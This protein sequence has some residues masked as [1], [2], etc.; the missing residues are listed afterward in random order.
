MKPLK[1]TAA[2]RPPRTLTDTRLTKK[3]KEALAQ[4]SNVLYINV[5]DTSTVPKAKKCDLMGRFVIGGRGSE[6]LSGFTMPGN[7]FLLLTYKTP[8]ARAKAK[9]HLLKEFFRYEGNK[10]E[11]R[12]ED[13]GASSKE[14][15]SPTVWVLPIPN[16]GPETPAAIKMGIITRSLS[17]GISLEDIPAFQIRRALFLSIPGDRF[18]VSFESRPHWQGKQIK[19]GD[20]M[21]RISEE[22]KRACLFCSESGHSFLGCENNETAWRVA[23]MSSEWIPDALEDCVSPGSCGLR[24]T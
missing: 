6:G 9:K 8:D 5:T 17:K 23:Q 2:T 1:I 10:V 16:A 24:D 21:R 20:V 3:D 14:D 22:S 11:L 15:S 19:V 4:T 12:I 13:Y 7:N 18:V